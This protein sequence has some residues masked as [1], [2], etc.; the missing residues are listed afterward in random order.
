MNAARKQHGAILVSALL[1]LITLTIIGISAMQMTRMQERMAGNS[2]DLNVAFQGAEAA[3]RDG[4]ERI[5]LQASR[6]DTC[7]TPG[8]QWWQRNFLT[9][10]AE[11][12]A[13]WW[14]ANGRPYG[15]PSVKELTE[16]NEDPMYVI[17]ELRDVPDDLT[18]GHGPPSS[19]DFYQV[20][21][22]ST[23]ITGNTNTVVQSTFVR[24][25]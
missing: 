17:E 4:E 7:A 8:C 16:L 22:R 13:A 3:L 1:I 2:R 19:R 18:I 9:A 24:R 5:R 15:N 21:A 12:P 25:Y 23:G 6:P 20:T 11:Q 10:L 14:A